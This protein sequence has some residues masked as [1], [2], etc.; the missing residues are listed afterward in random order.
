MDGVMDRERHLVT[1]RC[2]MDVEGLT[3]PDAGQ[4]E[5]ERHQACVH[6]VDERLPWQERPTR[7]SPRQLTRYQ[8]AIH[9]QRRCR[10]PPE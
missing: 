4:E 7:A 2:W 1:L 6:V 9:R 5:Q 8:L 3:A 10:Q